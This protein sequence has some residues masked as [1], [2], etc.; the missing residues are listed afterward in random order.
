MINSPTSQ[1]EGIPLQRKSSSAMSW[2]RWLVLAFAVA[3]T[4]LIIAYR[5]QLSRFSAYGYLGVFIVS[6]LGNATIIVPV[7]SLLSVFA[8]GSTFNPLFVGLIAGV[9]EPLGE[10]TGYMAGF[11]GRAVI[12]D[13]QTYTRILKWM[14]GRHYLVGYFTIF[15]LSAIPN[16]FFDLAGIAAGV[17]RLPVIGFLVSCWLGKTLKALVIAFAGARS[18]ELIERL[19]TY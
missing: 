14:Q 17:L 3:L 9:A 12:E 11:A 19:L 13:Q 2:S 7:P 1:E 18:V 4:I 8:A 16:P 5:N 15:V 6:L 10:L